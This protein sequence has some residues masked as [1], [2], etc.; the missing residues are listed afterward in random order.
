MTGLIHF[1]HAELACPR[2][3]AVALA[4]GFGDALDRLRDAY[5]LAMVLTSACRS[6]EHNARIGGHARSLHLIGNPHWRCDTCA[7][8]VRMVDGPA[9]GRLIALAWERGWSVGIAP[10]FLHLDRRTAVVGLPQTTWLY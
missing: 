2:S 4:P 10:S 6:A 9:R 7:V 1:S 3:R 5:G 8:D